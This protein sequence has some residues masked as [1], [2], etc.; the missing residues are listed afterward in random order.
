[1]ASKYSL[2]SM[3]NTKKTAG[4]IA[5]S[6]SCSVVVVLQGKG[7]SIKSGILSVTIQ[8]KV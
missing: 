2:R 7:H 3:T 6:D 8:N 4:R 5:K 1:M